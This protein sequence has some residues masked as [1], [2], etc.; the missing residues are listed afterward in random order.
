M[1]FKATVY[2]SKHGT[3]SRGNLCGEVFPN[4]ITNGAQV[5]VK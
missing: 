4:G 1:P 2:A 5:R 3:M